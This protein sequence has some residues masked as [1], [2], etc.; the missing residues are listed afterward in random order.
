MI[1]GLDLSLVATGLAQLDPVG[2]VGLRTIASSNRLRP[3]DRIVRIE[4][5]VTAAMA[6]A[7]L[8]VMEGLSFGSN[9]PSA[10]ERAALHYII[11]IGLHQRKVPFLVV[12][13]SSL[14]KFTCGSGAAKKE[15]MIR[16][17]F[18]RWGVEAAD[19]NQ[20]DAAALAYLGAGYLGQ[21]DD[22]RKPQIEVLAKLRKT[23]VPPGK[24]ANPA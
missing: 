8:V 4:D 21:L 13:P 15:M 20:A 2:I 22:L 5:E 6:G 14:K 19:N 12:P 17:V 23:E 7:E 3:E 11:R 24:P 16:E 18:R 9:D 10:Q 1:I